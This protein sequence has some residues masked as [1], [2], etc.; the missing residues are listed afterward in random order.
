[1][2]AAEL[3]EAAVQIVKIE[4]QIHASTFPL[5]VHAA[6]AGATECLSTARMQLNDAIAVIQKKERGF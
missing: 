3:R 2:T 5:S 6:L 1:M 4:D